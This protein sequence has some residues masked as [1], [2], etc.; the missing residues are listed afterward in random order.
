VLIVEYNSPIANAMDLQTR[1]DRQRLHHIIDLY[2]LRGNDPEEFN[3][4]LEQLF[5]DYQTNTIE[6]AIVDTLVLT[7]MALPPVKG[8]DF[9]DRVSFRLTANL[10]T[11]V[12]ANHYRLI[13]G[14]DG[15][16]L[17][18]RQNVKMA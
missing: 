11:L 16:H 14:L 7:W 3:Q 12:S 10:P 4:R 9:I 13:T 2:N 6:L 17:F 8:L 1:I 5:A 15:S 18:A